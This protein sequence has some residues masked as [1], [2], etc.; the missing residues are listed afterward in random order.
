MKRFTPLILAALCCG[1]ASNF[2]GVVSAQR[3]RRPARTAAQQRA[4]V[5][6]A[7]RERQFEFEYRATI[8]EIPV[9][10]RRL[11]VWIPVPHDTPFQRIEG[12][13][14]DSPHSYRMH[15][16][17]YGN[18]ILNISLNAPLP[19][20]VSV[21]MRFNAVR[22]EHVQGR[23][24]QAAATAAAT[25]A[26][27]VVAPERD[28]N[29]A[30]WLEPDR[31]VP[32]DGKVRQ[33]AR[34]VVDAAGAK[35]DLERARAIYNHVVST[36][37][38]DKSGQGWGRGDIYYA[39][40]ARRGNCTDFHAIFIG[41]CRAL[42][43]PARFTIGFPLPSDRGAGQVS[44]YHCW[45]EFYAEGIG[46]VPVDASEAAKDPARREYF[47]GAHDE[48]RIEFT[49]GRDLVLNPRQRGTP[50]NYFIYPYAEA[51]GQALTSIE[52]NF[53]YRDVSTAA[54]NGGRE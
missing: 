6:V 1:I 44:G 53:A 51:D 13:S 20:D 32:I 5:P 18:R 36:V 39:C 54:T 50:L 21:T 52:R 28:P 16:A 37:K 15:T 34:E 17:Q 38:Y 22:R 29:M 8:K 46:W 33:W 26:A 49:T 19:A 14:I 41:Y 23:L 27:A 45:A 4:R 12:L 7:P 11:E 40:D 42:G 25:P 35:T 48:N 43:I 24:R 30:R 10:A 47:F 9:G 31:L 3:A 2:F